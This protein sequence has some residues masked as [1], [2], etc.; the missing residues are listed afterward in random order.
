MVVQLEQPCRAR[1]R[2]R[3]VASDPTRSSVGTRNSAAASG[4]FRIRVDSDLCQGH[5]VCVSEAPGVFDIERAEN[6][7][8]VLQ[9]TPDEA[10]RKRV[11]LAVE[12]CPTRALSIDPVE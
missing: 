1:Y 8:V 7:V 12:H 9:V 3:A 4:A 2:R 6:K 11:E 5:G 10:L